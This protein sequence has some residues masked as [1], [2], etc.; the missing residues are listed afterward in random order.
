MMRWIRIVTASSYQ[1][2]IVRIL[3][4]VT[5]LVF[6]V[7]GAR[8]QS[9]RSEVPSPGRLVDVGGYRVHVNCTGTKAAGAP[10]VMIV[11]AGYSFDWDLVQQEVSRNARVCSYDPGG[12]AWSDPP[13][14]PPT[15]DDH[16][17][18]LHSAR[19][20]RRAVRHASLNGFLAK[21]YTRRAIYGK[22]HLWNATVPGWLRRSHEVGAARAR[23]FSSLHGTC[24]RSDGLHIWSPSIRDHA[25]LGRRPSRLGRG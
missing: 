10:S 22:T 20:V 13:L 23:G 9:S 24:T 2:A 7:A 18:E 5:L 1:R 25:L 17:A 14:A 21:R 3:R 16:I 12:C 15:C 6:S 11:G 4:A 8:A 19:S